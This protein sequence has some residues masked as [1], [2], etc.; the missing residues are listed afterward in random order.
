M[1]AFNRSELAKLERVLRQHVVDG[2]VPGLVALVARRDETHVVPMVLDDAR[3]VQRDTIFRI[4]SMTK[5]ITAAAAMMLV[6]EG[7]LRLD[8][9]I[10]RL[11]PNWR[12]AAY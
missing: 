3:P 8:E 11:A 5:P 1:M 4:A 7:A 6:E 12:I 2:S 9:P 10:G